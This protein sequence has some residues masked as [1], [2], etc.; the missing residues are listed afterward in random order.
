MLEVKNLKKEYKDDL[1]ITTALNGVSFLVDE[2]DFVAIMGPSGS[3]KSTLMHIMGFL[4]RPS[5]GIYEFE[6]QKMDDLTDD[7]LAYIRN[8]KMGSF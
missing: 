8:E 4:D 1:V 5:S 2:G 3:G 7:E 6:G